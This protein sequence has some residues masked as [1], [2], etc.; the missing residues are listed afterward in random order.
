MLRLLFCQ[1]ADEKSTGPSR[2]KDRQG[3]RSCVGPS[4]AGRVKSWAHLR[5]TG[6]AA[7]RNVSAH[8]SQGLGTAVWF[9][10]VALGARQAGTLISRP[11]PSRLSSGRGGQGD[12]RKLPGHWALPGV[13]GQVEAGAVRHVGAGHY[14]QPDGASNTCPQAWRAGVLRLAKQPWALRLLAAELV[15][16]IDEA[17][18]R[19]VRFQCRGTDMVE[20]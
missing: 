10:L 16:A 12:D 19:I 9:G 13:S 3:R 8:G 2:T 7:D 6:R 4:W 1:L 14:Q 11:R 18:D 17:L 5:P 20:Q 15:G